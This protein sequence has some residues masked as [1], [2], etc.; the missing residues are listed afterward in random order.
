[1]SIISVIIGFVFWWACH[2]LSYTTANYILNKKSRGLTKHRKRSHGENSG[3]GKSTSGLSLFVG[4]VMDNSPENMALGIS[5]VTGR[6]VNVVLIAVI[7]I[8][9]F[10][11]ALVSAHGM[12]TN[13]RSKKHILFLWSIPVVMGTISTA[14]GFAVLSKTSPAIISIAI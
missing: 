12:K 2:I 4:S 6:A 1:V 10:P 8:S 9:N 14:I 11:E 5:L 3:G 13:G 7:F